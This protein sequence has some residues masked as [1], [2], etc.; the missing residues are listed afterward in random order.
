MAVGAPFETVGGASQQGA[1]YVF[2]RNGATWVQQARMSVGNL[3]NSGNDWFGYAVAI[4]GDELVVGAPQ[5]LRGKAYVFERSGSVWSKTGDLAA[6][7]GDCGDN[8]FCNFG[9][10]VALLPPVVAVGEPQATSPAG[11]TNAGSLSLAGKQGGKWVL[12][13]PFFADDGASGDQVGY[14]IAL[15]GQSGQ[16]LIVAAGAPY[17]TLNG[18]T[19]RG[20]EYLWGIQEVSY[21]AKLSAYYGSPG[22]F[23]IST[24]GSGNT[25]LVGA[26]GSDNDRPSGQP[27]GAAY[28]SPGDSQEQKLVASDGAAED[29]FGFSV[30]GAG[31]LVA[32][33]APGAGTTGGFAGSGAAYVFGAS[34]LGAK[35]PLPVSVRIHVRRSAHACATRSVHL[36]VTLGVSPSVPAH[37][38]K[39]ARRGVLKV[40]A[41]VKL[42]G[43]RLL[44]SSRRAFTITIAR[45]RL[46]VR[47]HRVLVAVTT[48][49]VGNRRLNPNRAWLRTVV[50]RCRS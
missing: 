24:A 37:N 34:K 29:A 48:S 43:R 14:S 47:A 23:G 31:G 11:A 6:P 38:R 4:S 28:V 40:R 7:S 39:A 30:S 19:H 9:F 50:I 15:L 5:S 33:D 26:P 22:F 21:H 16:P 3:F 20:A 49:S 8:G 42:D 46:R 45:R 35:A 44:V 27:Q 41:V 2:V 10:S 13:S 1:V 12:G 18:Q 36:R 32:A 17:A 25:L